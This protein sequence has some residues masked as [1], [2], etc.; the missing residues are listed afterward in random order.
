MHM[1]REI[2]RA[3]TEL[4]LGVVAYTVGPRP[5]KL[6][7]VYTSVFEDNKYGHEWNL[8]E[9][10]E[11]THLSLIDSDVRTSDGPRNSR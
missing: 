11:A 7:Q 4:T 10:N 2:E 5:K 1:I 6:K 3:K 9:R 8:T